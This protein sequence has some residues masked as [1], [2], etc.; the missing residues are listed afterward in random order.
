MLCFLAFFAGMF[1]GGI[2]AVFIVFDIDHKVGP[3]E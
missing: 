3:W 1:I 2:L